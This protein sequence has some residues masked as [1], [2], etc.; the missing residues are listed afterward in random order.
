MTGF[1]TKLLHT[2]TAEILLGRITY[3]QKSEIYNYAH[4]YD[5]VAKRLPKA[6]GVHHEEDR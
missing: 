1:E 3:K 6:S 2:L 4:G 5:S